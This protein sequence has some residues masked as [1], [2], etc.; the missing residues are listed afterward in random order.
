MLHIAEFP[1]QRFATLLTRNILPH[2][3]QVSRYHHIALSHEVI[4][5]LSEMSACDFSLF[6]TGPL[7]RRLSIQPSGTDRRAHW[8]RYRFG[9][10]LSRLKNRCSGLRRRYGA[11]RQSIVD[12][13][14]ESRRSMTPFC[15]QRF[16]ESSATRSVIPESNRDAT[17]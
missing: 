13:R 7:P 5:A 14:Q 9:A 1:L 10:V 2:S 8:Q 12:D 11:C 15:F 4:Y 3:V 16:W 17:R 6:R